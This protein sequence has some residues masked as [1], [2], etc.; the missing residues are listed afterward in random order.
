MAHAQSFLPFLTDDSLLSFP[1]SVSPEMVVSSDLS[2]DL[3]LVFPKFVLT[4][5]FNCGRDTS[6]QGPADAFW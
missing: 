1:R 2:R 6:A 3:Y 4:L 5:C